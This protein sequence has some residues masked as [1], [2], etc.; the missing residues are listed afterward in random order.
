MPDCRPTIAQNGVAIQQTG[1]RTV[2]VPADPIEWSAE[3]S[4]EYLTLVASTDYGQGYVSK[5][6][7]PAGT[8]L[9]STEYWIPVA[10]FNAQLSDIQN[11]LV[12]KANAKDLSDEVE[13]AKTAEA[14]I[15]DDVAKISDSLNQKH[16]LVVIGDSWCDTPST[17]F[18]DVA[19]E[20]GVELVNSSLGG[21]G[22]IGHAAK[23]YMQLLNDAYEEV[24][25]ND[26]I[27]DE[28][29]IQGFINDFDL[30]A[31]PSV[32]TAFQQ[33]IGSVREKFPDKKITLLSMSFG[34]GMS[35]Y[36]E[37]SQLLSLKS[38][39]GNAGVPLI[40]LEGLLPLTFLDDNHHPTVA[41]QRYLHYL[42]NG[43][44][45]INATNTKFTNGSGN[46]GSFTSSVSTVTISSRFNGTGQRFTNVLVSMINSARTNKTVASFLRFNNP[47]LMRSIIENNISL[48]PVYRD[49][50]IIG[51]IQA[52]ALY[53][54]W[55]LNLAT[56]LPENTPITIDLSGTFK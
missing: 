46:Y 39:A 7:V 36:A 44:S 18:T 23:N 9:T 53:N 41:G 20:R 28:V 50:G 48:I 26:Y 14:T 3:T 6:D 54:S 13:R 32:D 42:F 56:D 38:S 35:T 52:E 19:S 5:K 4:Y 47:Y 30:N 43:G 1:P 10:S 16:C 27:V 25:T 45:P 37:C 34:A 40:C 12:T 11:Q 51:H 8:P 55:E 33:L 17:F 24:T 22:I 29:V 2:I 31:W 21:A 49:T 15:S